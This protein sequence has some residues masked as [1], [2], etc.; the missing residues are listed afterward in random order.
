[1]VIQFSL[2]DPPAD[3]HWSRRN[4]N[5]LSNDS[6]ASCFSI[7]ANHTMSGFL[8]RHARQARIPDANFKS[9]YQLH[10]LYD[11]HYSPFRLTSRAFFIG[12]RL[13]QLAHNQSAKCNQSWLRVAHFTNRP[14]GHRTISGTL[15]QKY[16]DINSKLH[17]FATSTTVVVLSLRGSEWQL[18]ACDLLSVR[19]RWRRQRCEIQIRLYQHSVHDFQQQQNLC[20]LTMFRNGV[21][22]RIF[23]ASVT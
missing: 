2:A 14:R 5:C 6:W 10:H 17:I 3:Y 9:K 12:L 13:R 23:L 1:M 22:A 15:N 20:K 18:V 4:A 16:E 19:Q 8:S 11:W 21:T 7:L